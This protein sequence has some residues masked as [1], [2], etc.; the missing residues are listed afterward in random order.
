MAFIS[1]LTNHLN[2]AVKKA[3]NSLSRDFSEIEKLQSSVKDYSNFIKNGYGKV[4]RELRKELSRIRPDFVYY[5]DKK[6]I[7]SGPH[8]VISPLDGLLNFSRGVA[9]F[10]IS[11]AVCDGDNIIAGT[12]YNPITDELFFAEKGKGAYK[13]GAR[14]S[15]RLRVS[16]RKDINGALI[17]SKSNVLLPVED[18]RVFGA[19]SLDLAY[20]AAGKFDAV[21]SPDNRFEDII[22]GVLIVKEAGGYVYDINQ[23]DINSGDLKEVLSSGNIMA[24]NASMN[25]KLHAVIA[26]NVID[27]ANS[28]K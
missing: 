12:I 24:V 21:V 11:V 23:K 13:E 27:A 28:L 9:Y 26:R 1:P 6:P 14:N 17:A 8:F 18:V 2:S 7:P 5:E 20:V 10:A 3:S 4:E 25:K 16:G 19:V 15:E 22:A